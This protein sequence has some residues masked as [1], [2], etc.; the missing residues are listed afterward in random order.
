MLFTTLLSIHDKNQLQNFMF[1]HGGTRRKTAN[2]R[3]RNSA[4]ECVVNACINWLTTRNIV[5][6]K[7]MWIKKMNHLAH[8]E[9][10]QYHFAETILKIY[11]NPSSQIENP[12]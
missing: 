3:E 10:R 11:F 8:S 12:C 1:L 5:E 9:L 4:R 6:C 2:E 7:G